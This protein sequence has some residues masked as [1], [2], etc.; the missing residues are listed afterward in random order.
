MVSGS[1][2]APLRQAMTAVTSDGSL[3]NVRSSLRPR[4]SMTSLT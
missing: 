3:L 1:C 4:S 2:A